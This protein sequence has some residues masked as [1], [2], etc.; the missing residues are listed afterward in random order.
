MS[1]HCFCEYTFSQD[2]R[3]FTVVCLPESSDQ[4]PV[5]VYRTPY[6]DAAESMTEQEVCAQVQEDFKDFLRYGF[7]V[8][9]QHCRGRGKSEGDC[10][11]YLNERADTL[12][13]YDWIRRQSFYNGEMY[14]YGR[15]Y[16]SSVHLVA[17]P[18][19]DDIKGAV[20]EVQD[21]ERYNC[22]FRNGFYKMGLH[23]NWYV[24]MYKKKSLLQKHYVPESFNMLPLSNFSQTVFDEKA[25][26]FDE[27]LR[28]PA[29]D[30]PFWRTHTGGGESHNALVHA[31]IPIL[32]VTGFYDI[33]TGGVFD[34]WNN[35][36]AQT[37]AQSALAV[38]PYDH[39]GKPDKQPVHFE[40]GMIAQYCPDYRQKWLAAVRDHTEKPFEAGKVTYY[41][42][43]EN[44]W[45]TDDFA[46]AP[47]SIK[48]PLGADTKAYRYNPYA[49][50]S[51]KGGLSANFG[52]TA[53]QDP[54]FQRSDILT[55][56]TKEFA[57]DT[58]VKGKMSAQLRVSSTCED[59]CFYIRLSLC[60]EE[61]DLGL[62]DDIQ[63]ISNFDAE[64]TP[65]QEIT[66]DF[67]FDEHA[68]VIR[69]GQKIRID[70]SSSAFPL[71]V[72]HTN[73]RGLQCD[74]TTACIADNT[75]YLKQSTLTLPLILCRNAGK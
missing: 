18:F 15:S 31:H 49:P 13:L 2:T 41:T 23:G 58:Y 20:L 70:I 51:F 38:S 37:R 12:A 29:A 47:H 24:G 39:S 11:P 59:T 63:Q 69:K 6:A 19:A 68:F 25:A 1:N 3:L 33:Y 27:I 9:Y 30:N 16:S 55:V 53:Y 67:S 42:L 64:Y 72:R 54:P 62:R 22:N 35:L 65:G 50:A 52:G 45:H 28:H 17:A 71:Y 46:P 4:S 66:I 75:V 43:F 36:D 73:R 48:L 56:Y 7:A 40:N 34:M 74:Q 26:D 57:E 8:V 32:L 14:L 61:G 21:S 5:V 10:I 60:T 44:R